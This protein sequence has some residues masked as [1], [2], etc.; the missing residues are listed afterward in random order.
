MQG[1]PMLTD[2]R[3]AL[4]RTEIVATGRVLAGELAAR[5]QVSQDTIRRD[6]RLLAQAGECRRVYGGAVAPAPALGPVLARTGHA[7]AEKSRLAGAALALIAP[8]QTLFLDGGSTNLAIARA[9]PT[10]LP[11]T[12]ATNALAVASALASHPR[13]KLILLGG[14][15]DTA[16]GV[17]LGAETLLAI[18]NLRADLLFLGSCGVDALVGVTAFHPQDAE[19]K[20]AMARASARIAVAATSDKLGTAA[21]FLVA[22][23]SCVTHLLVDHLAPESG[24][25]AFRAQGTQVHRTTA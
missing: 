18:A 7:S 4:I 15:H 14:L 22:D 5:L 2:Q 11:L 6:L 3:Q 24:L 17:C 12:V 23:P 19:V 1:I 10:D 20:R 13:I 21:P 8:G 25:E 16:L 9:L